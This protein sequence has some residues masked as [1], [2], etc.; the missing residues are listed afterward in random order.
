MG[1]PQW[2]HWVERSQ[3]AGAGALDGADAVVGVDE[4]DIRATLRRHPT[5]VGDRRE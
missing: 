5:A 4:D 3:A 1:P 2:P